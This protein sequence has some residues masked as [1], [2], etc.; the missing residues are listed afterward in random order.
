MIGPAWTW[1][2]DF[3]G[4]LTIPRRHGREM[5]S[6]GSVAATASPRGVEEPRSLSVEARAAGSAPLRRA[7]LAPC[8]Q[9]A[10][11]GRRCAKS[12]RHPPRLTIPC[13][14]TVLRARSWRSG[15]NWWGQFRRSSSTPVLTA[16]TNATGR[17]DLDVERLDRC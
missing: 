10:P 14:Y 12:S 7:G 9:T 16:A 5:E 17:V 15:D 2:K 13:T 4:A 6:G 3:V 1:G 8:R 11:L